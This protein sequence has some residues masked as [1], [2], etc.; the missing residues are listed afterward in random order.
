[1]KWLPIVQKEFSKAKQCNQK[2]IVSYRVHIYGLEEFGSVALLQFCV[3]VQL[4][5]FILLST[6]NHNSRIKAS[7]E[8]SPDVSINCLGKTV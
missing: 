4:W 6:Y 3:S 8:T 2:S 1:M 5:Y 7:K